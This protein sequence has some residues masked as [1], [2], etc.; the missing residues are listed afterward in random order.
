MVTLICHSEEVVATTM[1]PSL[2]VSRKVEE[3]E[4]NGKEEKSKNHWAI[5]TAMTM[6]HVVVKEE[7]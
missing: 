2:A 6:M 4:M 7:D 1:H 5:L 3:K